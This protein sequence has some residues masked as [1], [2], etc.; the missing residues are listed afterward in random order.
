MRKLPVLLL[1]LSV[2]GVGVSMWSA[3]P[4]ELLRSAGWVFAAVSSLAWW[5]ALALAGFAVRSRKSGGAA[6]AAVALGGSELLLFA[7]SPDP[8]VLAVKPVYQVPLLLVGAAVG[9]SFEAGR[10]RAA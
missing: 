9:A 6:G 8:L 2:I 4:L 3:R 5:F 7:F 10:S 1:V